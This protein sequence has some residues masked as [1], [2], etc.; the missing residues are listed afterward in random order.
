MLSSHSS[1]RSKKKDTG[2]QNLVSLL[3]S[4]LCLKSASLSKVLS[5]VF[6]SD[7]VRVAVQT[8]SLQTDKHTESIVNG[9]SIPWAGGALIDISVFRRPTIVSRSEISLV[10]ST[11]TLFCR[12]TGLCLSTVTSGF[13]RLNRRP[14]LSNQNWRENGRRPLWSYVFGRTFQSF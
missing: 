13:F 1:H 7:T 9:A 8:A 11:Q 10:K 5:K 4:L 14:N 12:G 3:S 6:A 2:V